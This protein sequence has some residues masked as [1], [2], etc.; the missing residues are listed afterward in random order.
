MVVHKSGGAAQ[1]EADVSASRITGYICLH[2]MG[3]SCRIA[4]LKQHLNPKT[5][6]EVSVLG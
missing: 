4:S 6:P 3:Y 2:D 5:T 1:A